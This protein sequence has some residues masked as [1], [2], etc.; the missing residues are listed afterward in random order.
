MFSSDVPSKKDWYTHIHLKSIVYV[1]FLF[2]RMNGYCYDELPNWN[3]SV[4]REGVI[5]KLQKKIKYPKIYSIKSQLNVYTCYIYIYSLK[6]KEFTNWCLYP[7]L[8][9]F[10]PS[11]SFYINNDPNVSNVLIE[12]DKS[13]FVLYH[14][15]ILEPRV[16]SIRHGGK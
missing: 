10:I 9:W 8:S 13:F 15:I 4:K 11:P 7:S 16:F 1:P 2:R 12:E 3:S 6:K 14:F 5:I